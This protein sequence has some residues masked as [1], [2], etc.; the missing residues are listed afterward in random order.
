MTMKTRSKTKLHGFQMSC[1]TVRS[2]PPIPRST[3]LKSYADLNNKRQSGRETLSARLASFKLLPRPPRSV[4]RPR[5]EAG[6]KSATSNGQRIGFT[7]KD[8][9]KRESRVDPKHYAMIQVYRNPPFLPGLIRPLP[10]ALCIGW[11]LGTSISAVRGGRTKEKSWLQ[12]VLKCVSPH[13][14]RFSSTLRLW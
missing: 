3:A 12:C 14:Y 9:L 13:S 1:I 7:L 4:P 5:G 6:R 2:P 11:R 8:I 10:R